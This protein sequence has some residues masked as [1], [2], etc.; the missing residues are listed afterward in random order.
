MKKLKDL[1]SGDYLYLWK[2]TDYCFEDVS[3]SNVL[4]GEYENTKSISFG[5]GE[6]KIDSRNDDEI[7]VDR[8]S[9]RNAKQ[10]EV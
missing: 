4:V 3:K 2:N 10:P 5:F 7:V 1:K 8:N 9:I 6:V